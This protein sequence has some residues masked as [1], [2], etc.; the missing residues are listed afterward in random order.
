M[1]KIKCQQKLKKHVIKKQGFIQKSLSSKG[2]VKMRARREVS[3][4]DFSGGTVD[5]NPPA[6]AGDTGLISAPGRYHMPWGN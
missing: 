1:S 3:L 4:L 2:K 6:D 5:K